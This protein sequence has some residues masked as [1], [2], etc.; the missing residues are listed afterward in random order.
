MLG[1]FL[2]WRSIEAELK[3]HRDGIRMLIETVEVQDKMI[4]AILV[5]IKKVENP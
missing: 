5:T 1:L 2:L 4:Q 3:L